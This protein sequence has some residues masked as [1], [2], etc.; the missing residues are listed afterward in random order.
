MGKRVLEVTGG[1]LS[2]PPPLL[3]SS[4][5]LVTVCVLRPEPVLRIEFLTFA[6]GGPTCVPS[7]IGCT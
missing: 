6:S 4:L 7:E 1:L 2:A 5:S 3:F